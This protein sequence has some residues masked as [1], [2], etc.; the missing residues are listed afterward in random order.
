MKPAPGH[1]LR[2]DAGDG[3]RDVVLLQPHRVFDVGGAEHGALQGKVGD[4]AN[5]RARDAGGDASRFVEQRIIGAGGRQISRENF[6]P[7]ETRRKFGMIHHVEA[8]V[9]LGR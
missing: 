7:R 1:F 2:G 9:L 4:L 6:P 3:D 5:L 8:V